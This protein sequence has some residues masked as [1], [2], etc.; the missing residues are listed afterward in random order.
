MLAP[1]QRELF[2]DA[3]RPPEGYQ[4][5]RG[6]GT[7]FSLNLLTLLVVPVIYSL[8]DRLTLTGR[9]QAREAQPRAEE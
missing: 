3:L 5:D 4:F 2:L 9:R 6:I 8:L 1:D 7:T